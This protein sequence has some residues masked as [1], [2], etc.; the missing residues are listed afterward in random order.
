MAAW[1]KTNSALVLAMGCW[2][3]SPAGGN[4]LQLPNWCGDRV[5]VLYA[6]HWWL[7]RLL[8]PSTTTDDYTMFIDKFDGR[9]GRGKRR[10]DRIRKFVFALRANG[11]TTQKSVGV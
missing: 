4:G 8:G 7:G 9:A 1:F 11:M 2:A 3:A 6:L 5:V 10:F